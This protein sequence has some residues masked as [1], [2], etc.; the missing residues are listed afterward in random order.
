LNPLSKLAQNTKGFIHNLTESIDKS[1][2]PEKCIQ[3][4]IEIIPRVFNMPFPT[5]NVISQ[6][7]NYL[8]INY[9]SNYFIWNISEESY[10]ITYFNK[11]V[12]LKI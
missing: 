9:G 1:L 5:Q 4:V 10:D 8:N 6:I 7:S 12:Y 11:Q 3:N 2:H